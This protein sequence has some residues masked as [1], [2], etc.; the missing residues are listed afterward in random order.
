MKKIIILLSLAMM[1][2]MTMVAQRPMIPQRPM[3]RGMMTQVEKNPDFYLLQIDLRQL[4]ATL[5]LDETQMEITKAISEQTNN[6]IQ[7]ALDIQVKTPI[8]MTRQQMLLDKSIADNL[9][10]MKRNL[11]KKQF[12]KY[13]ELLLTT[14]K[15]N[16]ILQYV[17]K[18]ED[19]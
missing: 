2:T 5:E 8:D 11:T 1:T 4:G 17:T 18:F 14:I 6:S 16:I 10:N 7:N 9:K 15:N 13:R 12:R 19:K 3:M